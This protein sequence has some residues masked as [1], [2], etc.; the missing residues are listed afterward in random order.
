[1]Q[2]K[3]IAHCL[4][5]LC[6]LSLAGTGFAQDDELLETDVIDQYDAPEGS[7]SLL[8]GD[9]DELVSYSP[10][11]TDLN[12]IQKEKG[13]K[14]IPMNYR[15]SKPFKAITR[16]NGTYVMLA[17]NGDLFNS[18]KLNGQENRVMNVKDK[19]FKKGNTEKTAGT[20]QMDMIAAAG[21]D[22]YLII[23]QGWS[24]RIVSVNSE[25]SGETFISYIEGI[26]SG[27]EVKNGTVYYVYNSQAGESFMKAV[28]SDG[29]GKTISRAKLP[30]NNA[31]GISA[32]NGVYY[33]LCKSEGKVYKFTIR[34][35]E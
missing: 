18:N 17:E 6:L 16:N 7:Q 25:S 32:E 12:I 21:N 33:T 13:R 27:V 8:K 1:M 5:T 23:N 15:W 35:K 14:S 28:P 10:G 9:N 11:T 26:P 19:L 34:D 22:V 2:I 4:A 20:V 31:Q 29:S 24:S 3:A 30:C